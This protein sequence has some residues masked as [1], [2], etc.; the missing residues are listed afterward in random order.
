MN[1]KLFKWIIGII[2]ALGVISIITL[3]I[4][5]IVLYN[6]VSMIT[7]IEKEVW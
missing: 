3:L 1:D 7:F 5:T 6:Q 4:I 2:I